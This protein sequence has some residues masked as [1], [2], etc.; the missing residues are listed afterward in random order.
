[1]D[2]KDFTDRLKEITSNKEIS[3]LTAIRRINKLFRDYDD[4]DLWPING[5]FNATD[6][7]IRKLQKKRREGL[8]LNIG[9]EYALAL[10]REIGH[11]VN[12]QY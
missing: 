5:K 6:R 4:S 8:C 2:Y 1:M 12:S 10:E 9:I 3:D 7:A 11:I